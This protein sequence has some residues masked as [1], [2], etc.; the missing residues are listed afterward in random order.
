MTATAKTEVKRILKMSF[1]FVIPSSRDDLLNR[2]GI[3]HFVVSEIATLREIPGALQELKTA[4]RSQGSKCLLH[5]FDTLFSVICL[6]KDV[7]GDL[8]EEAW[9]LLIKIAQSF[10]NNLATTLDETSIEPEVRK[11]GSNMVKMICYLLSQFFEIFEAED[12]QPSARRRGK[13]KPSDS[14]IDWDREK[15]CGIKVLLHLVTPNIHRLWD[16]PI[17][18]EEFVTLVTNC[19]YRLLE[20]PSITRV[21]S[22]ETRDA[23]SHLIGVMAKRY[24]HGLSASLKILQLLQHFEHLVSPLAHTVEII[25]NELGV[26]SVIQEIMREVGRL[27]PKESLRDP[28]GTRCI[29]AFL[30]EVAEKI[31]LVMLPSI[32]V[33]MCH[34][35]EESY[36]LRNG[37]LGVM[38]E[39]L[40]KV[41]SKDDLDNKMKLTRD[42]F[43][44]CLTEHIHDVNAFVR[45]KLL[46]IWWNIVNEKCL[47]LTWQDKVLTLV[48]GRLADK[49]SQVRKNSIQLVTAFIKCN[50]FAAKLSVEELKENYEKEKEKLKE[51]AGGDEEMETDSS[52]TDPVTK[53][54][55]E[56][57][58]P[59]KT[60]LRRAIKILH[61]KEEDEEEEGGNN[62]KIPENETSESVIKQINDLITE[63]KYED[64]VTLT[65]ALLDVFPQ[66]PVFVGGNSQDEE[67]EE[68]PDLK[69]LEKTLEYL[70]KIFS[71]ELSK[72][73]DATLENTE[74]TALCGDQHCVALKLKANGEECG[75]FSQIYPVVTVPSVYF[76][77]VNG[78]PIEVTAGYVEPNA[79]CQIIQSVIKNHR[80]QTDV[81]PP[82]DTQSIKMSNVQTAVSSGQP[83]SGQA[84][85]AS[86][87]H[88][89]TTDSNSAAPALEERIDIAKQKI[90]EKRL[91]K[92]EIEEEG[93]RQKEIERRK[94]GQDMAKLKQFQEEKKK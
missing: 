62:G 27:D 48:I 3:D 70:Y 53:K 81:S 22:K 37:V 46:Q 7:S 49:S 17:V 2:T 76:I 92:Q 29:S 84:D 9:Q 39:I 88:T 38:G 61:D 40:L 52:Q 65:W 15:E 64:A 1:E 57:W 30:V 25:T 36:T 31:P 86:S 80:A 78:S 21:T 91:Q 13:K 85:S 45:S 20:N 4:F 47:P 32:S 43:L 77:A 51:M 34:L 6:Q 58:K 67:G 87:N 35:D 50:P 59:L 12:T 94:L 83:A 11:D 10:V 26:K 23:I 63:E 44:E 24:N 33:L 75:F 72:K 5:K 66:I 14:G 8:K 73:M 71:G 16:P 28:S 19:G 79:F 74:V 54:I 60:K 82:L 55:D 69:S 41:L 68:E 42:Q 90:E 18:E 93:R 56:E 89:V